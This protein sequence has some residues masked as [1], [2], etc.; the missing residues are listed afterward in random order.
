[1]QKD[2]HFYAT[3]AVARAAGLPRDDAYTLAYSAQFVDDSDHQDTEVHAD[4][5]MMWGVATAHHPVTATENAQEHNSGEQR[6]VWVPF[7][8]IPGGHGDSLEEKLI[9]IKDSAIANEM[10]DNHMAMALS[11]KAY[12]LHLLGIASHVY[13][14][15]FSHY[16]F[17]GISSSYNDVQADSI[18]F[19]TDLD[20]KIES[21]I[22]RKAKEFGRKFVAETTSVVGEA[23]SRGLGHG[24]VNTYPDRPYLKWQVTFDKARPDGETTCTRD[25]VSTYF[26]GCQ[27]LHAKLSGFASQ[28][29]SDPEIIPF[30]QIADDVKTTLQFQ[31]TKKQRCDQWMAFIDKH[32]AGD[33]PSYLYSEWQTQRDEFTNKRHSSDNLSTDLYK[34]HQAAT[35]HRYFVLKDLLPSHGILVY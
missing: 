26:E 5:G 22:W 27:G 29:Y 17:S 2:M 16:G 6:R 32:F 15:T 14:D 11:D 8:F 30:V 19:I 10:F 34:F 31:G 28:Y 7:H 9:C 3:Y 23:L 35:Y 20:P 13:C 21:Y 1:M 18:K 12:A 25:N 24:A 33:N 4:G